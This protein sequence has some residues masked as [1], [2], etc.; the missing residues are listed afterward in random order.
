M[1]SVGSK[2]L[3]RATLLLTALCAM[4]A[5]GCGS[6]SA[7]FSSTLFPLTSTGTAGTTGGTV[8]SSSGG[9]FGGGSA[10]ALDPCDETLAR[11]RINISMRNDDTDDFIHYF[12]ILVAF[13]NGDAYPDGAVCPDDASFYT[14]FGYT[15]IPDGAFQEVGNIC[16]FGPAYVY[17]HEQGRFQQAGGD[18][19]SGIEPAAGSSSSFD[20]F[21]S[22]SGANVPIPDRIYFHNPGTG[23]GAALKVSQNSLNPCGAVV[24]LS[25]DSDCEQDGFYYVDQTDQPIGSNTL[26]AN[27]N[28]RVPS[29][30]QGTGC[31]CLA[32]QEPWHQLGLPGTVATTAACNEFLRGGS[33][34]YVFI[35]QDANP[36]FPQL[37]WQVRDDSGSVIHSFDDRADVGP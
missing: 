22:S 9:S 23:D 3:V 31:E 20:A 18:L 4:T 13:E 32:F 24:T 17:F 27:A 34:S 21:F 14:D 7:L 30:I 1:R 33:I 36:P 26:G 2:T 37:L 25:G 8:V 29:E 16:V 10:V 28:R 5:I 12:L 35:R 11:K 15:R 19:A 6:V